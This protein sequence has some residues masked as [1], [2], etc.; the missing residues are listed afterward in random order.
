MR[1]G[2]SL[3]EVMVVV[4]IIG[5][6]ATFAI[7]HYAKTQENGLDNEA[8]ANLVLIQAAENLY[9][10]ERN[11]F[12]PVSGVEAVHAKLNSYLSVNLPLTGSKWDYSVRVTPAAGANP[13]KACAQATRNSGP[14][15]RSW[16]IWDVDNAPVI[17]TCS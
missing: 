4:I 14:K 12:Y 17:D 5:I 9:K 3:L 16:H 11:S 8:K 7:P 15:I 1:L 2:F 13:A 6:L 10:S